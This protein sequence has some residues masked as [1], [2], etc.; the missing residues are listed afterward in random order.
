MLHDLTTGRF[1]D[2]AVVVYN[3]MEAFKIGETGFETREAGLGRKNLGFC[4]NELVI[5]GVLRPTL[6]LPL[7][8]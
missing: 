6:A 8:S 5:L 2:G 7:S 1:L 4:G 3:V